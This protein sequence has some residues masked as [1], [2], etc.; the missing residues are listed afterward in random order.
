MAKQNAP[1]MEVSTHIMPL[2][3]LCRYAALASFSV[4]GLHNQGKADASFKSRSNPYLAELLDSHPGQTISEV[5]WV[6]MD[7][8]EKYEKQEVEKT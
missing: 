6:A 8:L 1:L 2:L 5:L 7:L 3:E 4:D